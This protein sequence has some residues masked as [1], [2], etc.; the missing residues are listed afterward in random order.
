MCNPN[1]AGRQY[2]ND[3]TSLFFNTVGYMRCLMYPPKNENGADSHLT[4][5]PSDCKKYRKTVCTTFLSTYSAE[6]AEEG[7]YFLQMDKWP[8]NYLVRLCTEQKNSGIKSKIFYCMCMQT[9]S[10]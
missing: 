5:F 6:K 9:F 2:N 3:L 7:S 1:V 10:S 8:E 4:L